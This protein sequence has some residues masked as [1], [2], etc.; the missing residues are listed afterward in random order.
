MD[1]SIRTVSVMNYYSIRELAS[2]CWSEFNVAQN[3]DCIDGSIDKFIHYIAVPSRA[4]KIA[5]TP[6]MEMIIQKYCYWT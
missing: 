5:A 6:L 4:I 1:L 2:Y 3:I